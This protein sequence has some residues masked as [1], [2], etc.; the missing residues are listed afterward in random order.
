MKRAIITGAT[1]SIG[2][3]LIN[4]LIEKGIEVLVFCREGSVRNNNIPKSDLVTLK[5]CALNNLKTVKN[6]TGKTYDVFYHFAWAG[7][8]GAERNDMFLQNKNVEYSLD[9]VSAAKEFGCHTFIGAG[10][11][12]EY[13]RVNDVLKSDTPAFPENGYGMAK[14]CAG[15]MTREYAHML[16]M[17]HIWV[18]I[19]S[20]YGKQTT[21][22]LISY[23]I[24]SLNDKLPVNCTKGEQVW[25]Y[26]YNKDAA[27]AFVA[28]AE[29]GVDGK[30][31]PL[32]SGIGKPLKEYIEAI[33]NL[34]NYKA[35]INYGARSY[36]ANEV[37]YLVADITNF[38][39]DTGWKPEYSFV[40]GINEI[41]ANLDLVN[42]CK[43]RCNKI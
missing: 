6:D 11:Q 22:D 35:V 28:V 43:S 32:G 27:K 19:L 20:V 18:R 33:K 31:Y 13:G 41:I 40:E 26:L 39:N 12:A 5:Y 24:K 36:S 7:T 17:R 15:Q 42:C 14:L 34:I 30:V 2:T 10:S 9:A 1:G 3:A 4:E 8:T 21:T 29:N 37:M 38:T 23:V 16:G 25:D